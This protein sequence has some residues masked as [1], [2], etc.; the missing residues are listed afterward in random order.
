MSEDKQQISLK[1]NEYY[2]AFNSKDWEKF[3]LMLTDDFIYFSDNA[4]VMNKEQFI[5]FL[6]KDSW[7]GK[8]FNIEDLM[9]IISEDKSLGVAVYKISFDGKMSDKDITMN[10]I[11][12]TTFSK[13]NNEWKVIH[14][15]VSNKY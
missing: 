12:S 11:E 5:D 7:Q 8:S 10:A 14:S 9:V 6:K 13:I 15:H 1:L 4:A 2:N 3:S